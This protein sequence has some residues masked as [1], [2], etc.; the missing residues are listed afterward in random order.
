MWDDI[1]KLRPDRMKVKAVTVPGSGSSMYLLHVKPVGNQKASN[2]MVGSYK[3]Q[4]YLTGKLRKSEDHQQFMAAHR[5]RFGMRKSDHPPQYQFND[6]EKGGYGEYKEGKGAKRSY[7]YRRKTTLHSPVDSGEVTKNRIGDREQNI[8]D[9]WSRMIPQSHH[10]V[11][12]NHL[13]KL[14]DTTGPMEH[15][16]L[17]C[18]LL[19]AELHQRYVNKILDETRN[20]DEDRLR[21]DIGKEYK[22]LYSGPVLKPIWSVAKVI[23]KEAGVKIPR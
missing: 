19:A 9:Y 11:E 6:W 21:K 23:L 1:L 20:W 8:K 12:Y 3:D 2:W 17:P 14:V 22:A 13:E 5:V 7:R 18:V 4:T 10:I 16:Q 15:G